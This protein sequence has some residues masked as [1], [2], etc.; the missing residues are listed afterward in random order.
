[1][2]PTQ[3]RSELGRLG[4]SQAA[5]ARALGE[6][7]RTIRRWAAGDGARGIPLPVVILVR[8]LSSGKIT[9]A[10]LDH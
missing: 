5:F 4:I 9:L 7:E 1:M 10:D 3:F 6:H 8:L 2:T